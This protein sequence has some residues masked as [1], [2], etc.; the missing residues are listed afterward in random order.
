MARWLTDG[1]RAALLPGLEGVALLGPTKARERL[2]WTPEIT[3]Q[4]MCAEMVAEDL[5]VARRHA[6]LKAHGHDVPVAVE[7]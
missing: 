6:F 1:D 5:R 3:V 2:G 4:Q 7:N